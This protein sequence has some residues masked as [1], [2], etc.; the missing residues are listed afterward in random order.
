MVKAGRVGLRQ[1]RSPLSRGAVSGQQA[2]NKDLLPM[3][4]W[5]SLCEQRGAIQQFVTM[6]LFPL[7]N[8][9]TREERR[10]NK[11][12]RKRRQKRETA[13]HFKPKLRQEYNLLP[14]AN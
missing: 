1:D 8:R 13:S 10:N 11:I 12:D 2:V 3:T 7:Q 4:G 6:V 5:A 9:T 14:N